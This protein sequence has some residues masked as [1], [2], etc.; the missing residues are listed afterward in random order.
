MASSP[1]NQARTRIGV[2]EEV[3]IMIDS[4]R[5]TWA[6]S[7]AGTL[8]PSS[9][10][11]KQVSFTAGDTAGTVTITATKGSCKCSITFT[12]VAPDSWTMVPANP[13]T[14]KHVHGHPSAGF[15]GIMCVQPADVN[16]YA[17]QVRELD[18]KSTAFG[19][20][21]PSHN[22]VYH[23]NYPPPDRASEWISMGA[24]NDDDGTHSNGRDHIYSGW[25]PPSA[26]GTRPPFRAG[27]FDWSITWQWKVGDHG[28]IHNFSSQ[29]QESEITADGKCKTSKGGFSVEANWD[30][31]TS[32]Y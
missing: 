22:N 28:A 9:G 8:T 14:V 29:L 5:A 20:F 2:G 6:I 21:N 12:V 16:F 10:T 13:G 32:D 3:D 1:A 23:G 31:P 7:G 30:D 17:I 26:V 18:C 25:P 11:V 4:G 19:S 27:I 15:L 24:H